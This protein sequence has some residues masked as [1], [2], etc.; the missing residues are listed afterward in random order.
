MLLPHINSLETLKKLSIHELP[1]L[2]DEIRSY[3]I[4][5]LSQVGGHLASNLGSIEITVALHYVFESPI[6]KICWDVGHQCYTHKILT[7]RKDEL[8]KVRTIEGPSGFPRQEESVHD[9]Y[10]TG[11]AGTSISQ[12][13]GE[14]VARDRKYDLNII[15][16]LHDVIAV[17]G[18]AS[19]A[20]GLSFEALNHAGDIQSPFLVL[21]NDN[22]MSISPNVG[23]LNYAFSRIITENIYK[24]KRRQFYSLL[25]SIPWIGRYL[26]KFTLK[27]KTSIKAFITENHFFETLGFRYIGPMDG[28]NVIQ[29]VRIMQNLKN[30][31]VPTV[32]H[33]ITVKGKGY[34]PAEKDPVLYHGVKPFR[35]STGEMSMK[36]G[37]WSISDFV[38]HGLSHLANKIPE[39]CVITP[40]MKEGSGLVEFARLHSSKFF[41]VGIAEQHATTF[42]G[43]MARAG[44]KP[45]LC[46][47]STFLQRGYDQLI[48][49]ISLMNLP[50]KIVLDR[51]GC[52]GGDG[53]THQGVYDIAYMSCIPNMRILTACNVPEL[54]KMLTFMAGYDQHPISVR[55]PKTSAPISDW[56]HWVKNDTLPA[57]WSPFKSEIVQ[58]GKDIVLFTEG[59]MLTTGIQVSQ[60]LKAKNL[61][62]EVVSLKSLRPLDRL[63]I[64]RC[65]KRHQ[66]IFSL[67]NHVLNGGVGDIIGNQFREELKNKMFHKFGFPTEPITHGTISSIEK[68]YQ[69]NPSS[70]AKVIANKWKKTNS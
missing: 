1:Q 61:S 48:H 3:I 7:G 31:Q 64:S 40:A 23:A 55:F 4:D 41:D 44:M 27:A 22:E 35:A 33:L 13:L 19:I 21:L 36:E 67:E 18:D 39:L 56:N 6:D 15:H 65:I 60:L 45:F 12:A 10:N 11:H 69:L 66:Y 8:R 59:I 5:T 52:V 51:A 28:H 47:Y 46:I 16:Q 49:D 54:L 43:S 20:T 26:N 37:S 25:A 2:C 34:R 32:L 14:A 38:G 62:V 63:T 68:K 42:A 29:M 30:L 57:K 9:L 50:V 58:K 17:T 53:E 24:T 70:I